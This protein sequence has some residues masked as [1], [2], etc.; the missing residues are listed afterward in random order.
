MGVRSRTPGALHTS[1]RAERSAKR[2][3]RK[4]TFAEQ[5]LWK[6]LRTIEIAGSHF[7]RQAPFGPYIVDFVCHGGRMIIEVDGGVHD[8]EAV[9]ARDAERE[10][11]LRARGYAVLRL[12]NEDVVRDVDEVV[13]RIVGLLGAR[14]PTPNPSPQ[15]GGA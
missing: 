15:G 4:P 14:T 12:R 11:W 9:A 5:K 6:A 8:L 10:Q 3:R 13:R 1:E 7:R 2:M